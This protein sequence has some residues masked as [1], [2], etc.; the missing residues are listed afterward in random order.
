MGPPHRIF[1]VRGSHFKMSEVQ[2]RFC[3]SN[4]RF[5]SRGNSMQRPVNN[6]VFFILRLIR[7]FNYILVLRICIFS[8]FIKADRQAGLE[9]A[10]LT[11]DYIWNVQ[12]LCRFYKQTGIMPDAHS[13]VMRWQFTEPL[14]KV[15]VRGFVEFH[16]SLRIA[17]GHNRAIGGLLF[18]R[19]IRAEVSDAR[20]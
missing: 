3:R 11:N 14:I 15:F 13:K 18:C 5:L 1:S 20:S 2:H 6:A 7:L 8:F 10:L 19:S 17:N 16:R 12:N 9:M 4:I